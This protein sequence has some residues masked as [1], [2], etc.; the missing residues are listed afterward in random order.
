[1]VKEKYY[2]NLQSQQ[3]SQVEHEQNHAITIYATETE[4][5]SL[6]KIFDKVHSADFMT[7]FRSYVPIMPYHNAKSND[8]YDEYF[9]DAVKFIYELGDEQARKFI[10]ESGIL[11]DRPIDTDYSYPDPDHPE[12]EV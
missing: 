9:T 3:I 8:E 7:F 6:R 2:V 1:M 5:E 11:G 10:E 4:V 12:S